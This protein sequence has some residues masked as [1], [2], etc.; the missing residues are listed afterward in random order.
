LGKGL[1]RL[2]RQVVTDAA[3]DRP[4]LIF[5]GEFLR[6]SSG[7]RVRRTIGV[8]LKRDRRDRDR[9]K[10]REPLFQIFVFGLAVRKR[11]PPA[12]IVDHDGDVIRIVECRRAALESGIVEVPFWRS[13]PPNELGKIAPVFVIAI[14]AA[15]GGEIILVPPLQL[16]TRRQRQPARLL[17]TDQTVSLQE[18]PYSSALL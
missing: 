18:T 12:V 3:G 14:A 17:T 7:L 8:A 10:L 13:E 15:V 9:W 6:V 5:A 16:G 1:R 11:K 2:L 4:V